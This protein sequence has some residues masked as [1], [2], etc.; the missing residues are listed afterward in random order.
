VPPTLQDLVSLRELKLTVRAGEHALQRPIAWVHTSEFADPARFLEGG[1]LL[2]TTGQFLNRIGLKPHAYVQRLADAGVSG[3]G[4]GIGLPHEHT[5]DRLVDAAREVGLPLLEVPLEVPFIAI[6]KAVSRALAAEEYAAVKRTYEAQH[7]LTR[8]A[9]AGEGFAALIRQL[10]HRLDAWAVLLDQAG[11]VVHAAPLSARDRLSELGGEVDRLRAARAPASTAF[12]ADGDEVVI[13]SLGSGSR[14]RGFLGVGRPQALSAADRHVLNTAVSLLTLGL[15]QSR[16]LDTAERQLRA[17]LFQ[18]LLVG[19]VGAAR[20]LARELWGGLPAEPI[21]LLAL[22]GTADVRTAAADLITAESPT[23][24]ELAFHADADGVTI[25]VLT[26]DAPLTSWVLELPS[27]LDGLTIGVSEPGGYREIADRHRQAAQAAET[28]AR[29]GT[30]VTRFGEL[31]REGLGRF[32]DPE[33]A[34]VFAAALLEPL[35][36]HDETGRGD[37]VTSLRVW[38]EQHGQWDPAAARLGIHRHTLRQRM[39]KV[40]QLLGRSLDLPGTRAELWLALQI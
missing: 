15:E 18:L 23:R 35:V 10:A 25:V 37:L 27:R 38:L 1:E 22:A 40:E 16:R 29:T 20:R 17:G 11:A 4:F 9:V 34:Q 8:A 3:L 33:R 30:P 13:Q 36:R 14:V 19:Q 32:I 6:S 26:E 31:G 7:A 2:L 24:R 21:T 28:G 5:P 39:Q 12:V